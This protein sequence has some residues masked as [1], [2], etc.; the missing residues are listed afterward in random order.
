LDIAID[1]GNTRTKTGVFEAGR[2]LEKSNF[3]HGDLDAIRKV[4]QKWQIQNAIV[5]NTGHLFF[6]MDDLP[7]RRNKILLSHETSLPIVNLYHTP[8]TLG[9]DRIASVVGAWSMFPNQASF[10]IDAGTCV[11]YD[12]IDEKGFYQGG[13]IAPGLNM[14][15]K[16][17][18]NFTHALPLVTNEEAYEEGTDYPFLGRKTETALR[19]GGQVGMKYEM[20][21]YIRA[22][23]TKFKQ[24]NI[25][26]TGGDAVFF[27]EFVKTKIFV[28]PDLV[29]TGLEGILRF[30]KSAYE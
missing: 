26:L 14:R 17:M 16:A 9:K 29:L 21:G 7:V 1:V 28:I 20:E 10:V 18:H 23:Q 30:Q 4:C 12:L 15:Y 6:E 8:E 24:I 27:D 25:I 13:N 5:S 22:L 2:M 11:T 19:L 3:D